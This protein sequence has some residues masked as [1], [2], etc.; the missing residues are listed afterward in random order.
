MTLMM[1][2]RI[3]DVLRNRFTYC[4]Y[5]YLLR[6][7]TPDKLHHHSGLGR[8]VFGYKVL[9][10]FGEFCYCSCSPLLQSLACSIPTTR[11]PTLAKPLEG[12][13]VAKSTLLKF[14]NISAGPW[15]NISVKECNM[16]SLRLY[17]AR[18]KGF[19]QVA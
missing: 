1:I 4:L 7:Q 11:G 12:T 18:L 5:L 16:E 19:G 2:S 17:R 3:T 13:E 14:V 8:A 15:Q 9:H 10:G 6:L